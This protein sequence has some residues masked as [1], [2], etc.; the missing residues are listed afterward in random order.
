MMLDL[1]NFRKRLTTGYYVSRQAAIGGAARSQ[2]S[3][4]D[5]GRAMADVH[6]YFDQNPHLPKEGSARDLAGVHPSS[7]DK[8]QPAAWAKKAA[9]KVVDQYEGAPRPPWLKAQPAPQKAP[10]RP[11]GR[12]GP[13]PG[14]TGARRAAAAAEAA[15]RQAAAMAPPPPPASTQPPPVVPDSAPSLGDVMRALGPS[16]ARTLEVVEQ[17]ALVLMTVRALGAARAAFD[18]LQAAGKGDPRYQPD[19]MRAAHSVV[20]LAERLVDLTKAPKPAQV[21]PVY[22]EPPKANEAAE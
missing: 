3:R 5:K 8:G 10:G 6:A 14:V 19:S 4:N 2:M 17:R 7:R 20:R 21:E 15:A 13:V 18:T 9:A 22:F 11:P 16:T 1:K 12:R